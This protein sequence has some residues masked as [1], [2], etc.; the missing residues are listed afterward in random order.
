MQL[1]WVS[2]PVLSEQIIETDPSVSTVLS[3]LHR[4]LFF[5]IM[6]ALMVMLAVKATGKPSGMNATA[7]ETQEMIRLGT[8]IQLGYCFLSHAPLSMEIRS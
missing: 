1:T 2:V 3:D 7:T 4:I 5:R 6:L 8:L